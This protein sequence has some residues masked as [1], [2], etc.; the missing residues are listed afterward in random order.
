MATFSFVIESYAALEIHMTSKS[1]RFMQFITLMYFK[2]DNFSQ[3]FKKINVINSKT[4]F[5][6]EPMFNALLCWLYNISTT[7]ATKLFS[8]DMSG[9]SK[10]HQCREVRKHTRHYECNMS[11]AAL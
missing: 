8:S 2:V 6:K 4:G 5:L 9:D 1:H 11:I 10:Q 3:H 7:W